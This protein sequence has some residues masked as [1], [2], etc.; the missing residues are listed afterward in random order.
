MKLPSLI[1]C[2]LRAFDYFG[3]WIESI[4]FDNMKQVRIDAQ[5]LN[6]LFVDFAN[7]YG[8]TIKTHRP[9]RPRTKGKVEWTVDYIKD[10]FLNG[11]TF[12]DLNDLNAQ[13][14][15]WLETVA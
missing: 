2:H 7:H 6:P 13:A 14:R 5:T 11:W 1:G 10:N 15:H 12:I 9:C 8:I 4:L 3:G